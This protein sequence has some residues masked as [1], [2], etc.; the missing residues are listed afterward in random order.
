M[1]PSNLLYI[2]YMFEVLGILPDLVEDLDSRLML[3][4]IKS[5]VETGIYKKEN[6]IVLELFC[7][8]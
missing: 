5:S 2:Y 1:K 7:G 3:M 6:D 4:V 8:H